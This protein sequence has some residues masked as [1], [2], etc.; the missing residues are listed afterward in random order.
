MAGQRRSESRLQCCHLHPS[1]S[2]QD[3]L[4]KLTAILSSRTD[5]RDTSSSSTPQPPK[6]ADT[7]VFFFSRS[8]LNSLKSA[9]SASLASAVPSSDNSK[10]P[11][12]ISTNDAVSALLFACVTE[13]RKPSNSTN[14]QQNIPFGLTVSGRRLLDPPLPD[15]YVGNMSLF[16]HLDL[17]LDTVSPEPH[18][19]AAIAQQIRNRLLQ[20]DDG[21]VKRL[22]GALHGVDDVGKVAG[23][24]RASKEWQFMITTV[25][26]LGYYEMDWGRE[27]GVKCERYRL[28]K[29]L[30]PA[31]DGVNM[32]Y[33]ELKG[34]NNTDGEEVAGLEV[35]VGLEKGAMRRLRAMDEWTRWAQWRCS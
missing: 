7:E 11:S 24:C 14:P 35:M 28:P 34:E 15:D 13:A 10:T 20:L 9:M 30:G 3:L 25:T 5:P 33:P 31:F 32:V 22:I 19:I 6:E 1:I 21:F 29:V 8:K 18:R 23:A 4:K 17:P 26:S 27:I 12:Y 16:C 2:C